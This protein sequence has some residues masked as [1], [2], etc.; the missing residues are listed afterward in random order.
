M[1]AKI[2]RRTSAIVGLEVRAEGEGD[3][4][5]ASPTGLV[6]GHASVFDA[7]TVLYK[8][9]RLLVR[10]T[11]RRGAFARAIREAQDVKALFN[12]D[13]NLVLGRT[14]SGTL[15]L[16]EDETGLR[17]ELSLPDTQLGRDVRVLLDRGDVDQNSFAFLPRP[18]GRKETITQEGDVE[19]RDVEILEVDLYDISLVTYPAYPDATVDEIRSRGGSG[20]PGELA[21]RIDELFGYARQEVCNYEQAG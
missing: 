10:E 8:S 21:A 20:L 11:I 19:V 2:E 13:A 9:D 14:R 15:V 1:A 17:Y 12:H 3:P 5:P 18:G 7:P 4:P 6:V 16:S